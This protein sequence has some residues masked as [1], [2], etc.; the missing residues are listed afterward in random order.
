MNECQN[1][2]L[3]VVPVVLRPSPLQREQETYDAR[4][5]EEGTNRIKLF[6]AFPK[7]NRLLVL[8]GRRGEKECNAKYSHGSNGQ[9]DVEAPF[10]ISESA[11]IISGTSL[12]CE[13][14]LG[15]KLLLQRVSRL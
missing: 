14:R 10:M 1:C 13:T 8:T 2:N 9:I 4:H 6:R 11:L 12:S 7:S 15:S 3:T 5:E